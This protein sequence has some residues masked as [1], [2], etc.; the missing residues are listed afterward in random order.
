MG[1]S[2]RIVTIPHTL[3][4]NG[5][6]YIYCRFGDRFFRCS[7]GT[8]SP[9]RCRSLLARLSPYLELLKAG[10][11]T[12][13][14]LKQLIVAMKQLTQQDLDRFMTEQAAEICA[15]VENLPAAR[16]KSIRNG[17]VLPLTDPELMQLLIEQFLDH[18]E[19]HMLNGEVSATEAWLRE[20]L[21]QHY[22][23]GGMDDAIM[24]AA[25][26]HNVLLHQSQM[27]HKALMQRDICTYQTTL[28]SIRQQAPATK[29]VQTA[30][31]EPPAMT[32]QEAWNGFLEFKSSWTQPIRRGNEKYFEVIREVL[33]ADTPINKITHRDI[34]RLLE[35]VEDLPK[36]HKSPYNKLNVIECLNL[37]DVPEEDKISQKTVRD[38]LK[39]CQGLFSTYLTTVLG[40]LENSP[41]RNVKYE[42]KS[43]SY[44]GFSNTEMRKMV[45]HY[46]TLESEQ[47]WLFTLLAYTGARRAEITNLIASAVRLD[48][49]SQR[50]YIMI[51]DSKTEAGIRQV[52]IS[53]HVISAGFLQ[54]VKSKEKEQRLF[55]SFTNLNKVTHLFQTIRD[56]LG[57]S[58][59]D[60]YNSRRPLHSLRH[61]FATEA[62]RR[63]NTLQLVQQTIGHEHSGTG[64]TQRYTHKFRVS[65]LLPVVD[66]IHWE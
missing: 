55:P 54:Y 7:L 15:Y 27:A 50:Y 41:T 18:Y 2:N 23:I 3:R 47:K 57:I 62:Q 39:L 4:R 19:E 33:G 10:G 13:S 45:A 38:Y 65:D 6:Y 21:A 63:G 8:D 17:T 9:R 42:A 44:G 51:E 29:S 59:L 46:A 14:S 24:I 66:C 52:P 53:L 32:L 28:Q 11:I 43:K 56:S 22:D 12:E 30:P 64:Q 58:P 5:I 31:E 34:K 25:Q 35:V 20:S 26:K 61:T 16:T 48:D 60:D 40:I 36:Q 49:D 1:Y 37:D